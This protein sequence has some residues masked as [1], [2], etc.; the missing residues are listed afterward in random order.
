MNK[1]LLAYL[2]RKV[3]ETGVEQEPE[4]AELFSEDNLTFG[5]GINFDIEYNGVL[6]N[7]CIEDG[8]TRIALIFTIHDDYAEFA[9]TYLYELEKYVV[10]I[11]KGEALG[12]T[13]REAANYRMIEKAGFAEYF[14]EVFYGGTIWEYPFYISP[15]VNV[16]EDKVLDV[17]I[18]TFAQEFYADEEAV[19][20][21]KVMD[22]FDYLS[23]EE[24][25]TYFFLGA[26]YC[27]DDI[28][29]L[30][31]FMNTHEMNDTHTGNMTLIN[32]KPII[33]DYAGYYGGANYRKHAIG[34]YGSSYSRNM[35]K[36]YYR[37]RKVA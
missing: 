9:P 26:G 25:L 16:D 7:A 36:T 24:Q 29:K 5:A 4:M 32:G 12:Y 21:D 33:F 13:A 22:E 6:I 28:Y 37:F 2:F 15:Y 20:D 10:K 23:T 35:A 27:E 3:L 11:D 19:V 14:N 8:A 18:P 17:A 31:D 1:T 30:T 34:D